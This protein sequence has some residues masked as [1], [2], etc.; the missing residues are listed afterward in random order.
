MLNELMQAANAIPDLPGTLHKSLKSLPKCSTYRIF[1]DAGGAVCDVGRVEGLASLRKWQPS[2]NGVSIPAFSASAL[3]HFPVSKARICAAIADPQSWP[4]MFTEIR[5]HCATHNGRWIDSRRGAVIGK[6]RKSLSDAPSQLQLLLPKDDPAYAVLR[7][8]C[9]RLQQSSPDAFFAG[10][11]R[12]LESKLGD[13]Y[14]ADLFALYCSTAET[15]NGNKYSILLDVAEW[16]EIGE[17]PIAHSRTTEL[18]DALLSREAETQESDTAAQ[19]AYGHS[20]RNS[21]ETF[22]DVNVPGLGKVT[23]RAMTADAPCQFRYGRAGSDS[24]CVGMESRDR[25]KSAIESLSRADRKGKTWQFRDGWLFLFYAESANTIDLGDAAIADLCVLPDDEGDDEQAVAIATFEARAERIA[26]ALDGKYRE[27]ETPVNAIVLRKPDRRRTKLVAHHT[28]TM[29]RLLDAANEWIAGARTC[30][31]LSFARW[32]KDRG[33]RSDI[34]PEPPYPYQVARWLNTFWARSGDRMTR[35][36]LF[37]GVDTLSLLLATDGAERNIA[38]RGLHHAV[39]GWSGFLVSAGARAHRSIVL[40]AGDEQSEALAALP[41]ILSLLLFKHDPDTTR[42]GTMSSPAYLVGRLL[43][44][45]DSIHLQYCVAV[46]NGGTPS[47]LLGNALMATA[48]DS[49]TSAL[50]LYGQRIVP[51]HAWARTCTAHGNGPELLAKHLL[52]LIGDV[53]AELSEHDIP[54]RTTDADKARIILGYLSKN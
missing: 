2:A 12:W 15:D 8:L 54:Q 24:F 35:L 39:A 23:L 48:L 49:P 17:H 30:P 16:D 7:A 46:R 13:F 47:Q 31:P 40:N 33:V 25:A 9:N 34:V 14:D 20:A 27:L 50:A 53:C 36:G 41:M 32:G 21:G 42:E 3:Y 18:L 1:L 26:A 52:S 22:P 5:E 29:R 11:A 6:Y 19:D 10:L 51:Y 37:S 4:M 45:T 43:A 44:L 28:F 38:R